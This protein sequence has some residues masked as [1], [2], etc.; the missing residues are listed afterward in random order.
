[1]KSQA[2]LGQ[3]EL[4]FVESL[5][6]RENQRRRRVLFGLRQRAQPGGFG[7]RAD[8]APKFWL[9]AGGDFRVDPD[10]AQE[11]AARGHGRAKAQ[12]VGDA[13]HQ[14]FG[15][16]GLPMDADF[17][18]A[19]L[20]AEFAQQQAGTLPAGREL[21]DSLAH[22]FLQR[23]GF[24]GIERA[25]IPGT[26]QF[27]RQCAAR[28]QPAQSGGQTCGMAFD[29]HGVAQARHFD[30][31]TRSVV[32]PLPAAA[33]M[34][35]EFVV[36][37]HFIRRHRGR[38]ISRPRQRG[39]VARARRRLDTRRQARVVARP[40]RAAWRRA[41]SWPPRSRSLELDGVARRVV[42]CT[43]D[44][45]PEQLAFVRAT[46][47]ADAVIDSVAAQPQARE[48][49]APRHRGHRMDP[50]HLRHHGRAEIGGAQL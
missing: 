48:T 13:A 8:A 6:G 46:A 28:E 9:D 44:L 29:V 40:L 24:L 33:R 12:G 47:A 16:H 31:M 35:Y 18:G 42:L 20:D 17:D 4:A 39:G 1:M 10:G 36:G 3:A 19:V 23:A 32:E 14:T 11:R 49:A 21:L 27:R 30:R 50:A 34:R 43:P 5:L 38:R 41:S 37:I 15:P 26:A 25:R 22:G 2:L 45:T 7:R